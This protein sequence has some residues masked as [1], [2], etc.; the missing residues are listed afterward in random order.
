MEIL[1]TGKYVVYG[2][3]PYPY[4]V[5]KTHLT[6]YGNITDGFEQFISEYTILDGEKFY[7]KEPVVTYRKDISFSEISE[8]YDLRYEAIYQGE[9]FAV[10]FN[11]DSL[12][13]TLRWN[14]GNEPDIEGFKRMDKFYWDK[15]VRISEIELVPVKTPIDLSNYLPQK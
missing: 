14:H 2:G 6:I 12:T 11:S 5:H 4:R 9:K 15:T 8:A 1:K 7:Y 3:K 10:L 13:V